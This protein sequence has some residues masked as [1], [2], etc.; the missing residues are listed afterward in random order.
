MAYAKERAK[1]RD[2]P[3]QTHTPSIQVFDP[4]S[5]ELL[6]FKSSQLMVEEGGSTSEA[7]GY[8]QPMGYCLPNLVDPSSTSS[9]TAGFMYGSVSS[10]LHDHWAYSGNSVLSFGHRINAKHDQEE[11][12]DSWIEAMDGDST[13]VAGLMHGGM[14]E[15]K[16]E[17]RFGFL[18][19][20]SVNVLNVEKEN[21]GNQDRVSQKRLLM[22]MYIFKHEK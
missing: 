2:S 8:Y 9:S 3:V 4:S 13:K 11:E 7:L 18:Y 14:K 22:V 12:C 1:V 19:P 6:G 21:H 20:S 10:S 16:S 15:N 5:L 17:E